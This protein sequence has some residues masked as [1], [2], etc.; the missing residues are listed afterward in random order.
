MGLFIK[1]VL[2]GIGLIVG[3]FFFAS[4]L[5]FMLSIPKDSSIVSSHWNGRHFQNIERIKR[6]SD[7]NSTKRKSFFWDFYFSNERKKWPKFVEP[8][9]QVFKKAIE[10]PKATFINHSTVLLEFDGLTVLTDPIYSDRCSPFSFMGPKRVHSPGIAF[11]QLPKI[12]VVLISH[13][14][15]DHLDLNTLKRLM[16]RDHP[17]IISGLGQRR[18]F[19]S[20]GFK[21]VELLDWWQYYHLSDTTIQFVPTQHFSSRGLFDKNRALWG[22]FIIKHNKKHVYFAGDTG[23]GPFVDDIHTK[24]PNGFDLALI[25]IGAYEP[26]WMMSPVHINPK[27]ALDMHL[28]IQSKKSIGI[29]WGT[30]QLTFEDRM[31]PPKRLSNE[32]NKRGLSKDEFQAILPGDSLFF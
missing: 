4:W 18:F 21:H 17:L 32:I 26:A 22:G 16:K 25:P 6:V 10:Y 2:I 8:K 13:N 28:A 9:T 5:G 30:F 12:D 19:K 15:Y 7:M 20:Q 11:E 14:H 29:H 1:V 24:Y 27:E 31:D 23:Y 3:L